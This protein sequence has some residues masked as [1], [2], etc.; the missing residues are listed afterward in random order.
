[1]VI[2]GGGDETRALAQIVFFRLYPLW[3]Y[4][5]GGGGGDDLWGGDYL[6]SIATRFW[7]TYLRGEGLMRGTLR[8]FLNAGE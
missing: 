7:W 2:K 6:R 3:A 4:L 1:M 8:Y 5:R